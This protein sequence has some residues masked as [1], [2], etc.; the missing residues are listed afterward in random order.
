MFIEPI[1][2][3]YEYYHSA[4]IVTSLLRYIDKAEE[5]SKLKAEAV[6]DE[7]MRQMIVDLPGYIAVKSFNGSNYYKI[8][9]GERGIFS[10][11]CP[12]NEYSIDWC[13]HIFLYISVIRWLKDW[14]YLLSSLKETLWLT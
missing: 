2:K 11:E 14:T 9:F 1:A 10:C 4:V 3:Y 6:S 13:K 8:S 7:D 5:A 12:Y